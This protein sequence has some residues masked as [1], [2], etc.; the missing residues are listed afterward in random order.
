MLGAQV[1]AGGEGA[2]FAVEGQPALAAKIY[3]RTPLAPEHV[4]KVAAMV[5]RRTETLSAV[6]AWPQSLLYN[7]RREAC[8]ILMPK[9]TDALQLH[10]LYGTSNRRAQFPYAKWHH[11][12][13]AARNVA[14]AFE[15]M[16][17]AGIVVGDVNQ[18]NM[19]VDQNMCVRF[20]DCDSFQIQ[21]DGRTFPCPVGTPHF[22]PPELQAKK[23]RD[24]P[25]TPEQDRFGLAVLI[26][27]LVFVGRHPFAGRYYG[28]GDLTI[29]RAI[30]E[31]RF[32]FSANRSE[33]L[34]E[35]PPASL[36]LADVSPGMASLFE[37]AFRGESGER[38]A[39]RQWVEEFDEVIQRRKACT[40]D[41]AHIYYGPARECPWCRI[42]DEG[43]P[44]FFVL[45]GSTST[46]A[47]D[48]LDHLETKLKK[49]M[50]PVFPD[51]PPGQMHIPRAIAPKRMTRG[52]PVTRADLGS[53]LMATGA[54]SCLASPWSA[55]P[56]AAGAAALAAAS[57]WL[58]AGKDGQSHRKTADELVAKLEK[59]Q[60]QLYQ[61]GQAV[62]KNHRLRHD[63]FENSVEQLKQEYDNYRN[64]STQ[65]HDVLAVYRSMQKS[66]YLSSHLIQ[67]NVRNIRGM[68]PSRAAALASYGIESAYDVDP[69]RLLGLP[70]LDD[71][72]ILELQAWR[73]EV[74]RKFVYIP[75]HGVKLDSKVTTANEPTIK[76][77]KA[78]IARRILMAARQ[79]ESVA[80]AGREHLTL[81]LQDFEK[82]ADQVRATATQLRDFQ[83]NRRPLERLLNRTPGV[84]LAVAGA[85]IALGA[86]LYW[87]NH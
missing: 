33:T 31:R 58:I 13:L 2:I 7:A 34:V 69:L 44:A 55:W 38:P 26:F 30:A 40:M 27:H 65:L 64:A 59:Q 41:Q 79:L 72:R 48:R 78:S 1:G 17:Q 20:I 56:L 35:P 71:D 81:D 60:V 50:L 16:H 39:A 74:E 5:A 82:H 4:E 32:A 49:L 73:A 68:T 21:V 75:E 83:S 23:L 10:E 67:K 28:A 87:M 14:A 24:E 70:M 43:G 42:E 76:R 18:G 6:S 53:W 54:A 62:E 15:G 25:R 77:F 36:L 85:A 12:V 80:R 86:L 51:L 8:G 57:G 52:L 84:I 29:E 63:N 22:T 66:R 37:A 11:L 61:R 3:H 47:A 46:I 45:G 19:L 9:I